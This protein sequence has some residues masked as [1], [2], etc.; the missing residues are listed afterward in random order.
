MP[1][2]Q[3]QVARGEKREQE[4]TKFYANAPFPKNPC[5]V[6]EIQGDLHQ[7]QAL[8]SL[9]HMEDGFFGKCR[10]FSSGSGLSIK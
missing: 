2:E 10:P 8:C 5:A 9:R 3:P 1:E 7:I 6:A 4:K